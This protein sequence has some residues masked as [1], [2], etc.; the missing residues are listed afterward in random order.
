MDKEITFTITRDVDLKEIINAYLDKEYSGEF[1]CSDV[2]FQE[3]TNRQQ[4]FSISSK[5]GDDMVQS[6]QII[7]VTGKSK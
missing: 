2:F 3:S 6:Q 4:G 7:S 1:I 5:V